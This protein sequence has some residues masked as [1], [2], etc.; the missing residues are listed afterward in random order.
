MQ[1]AVLPPQTI[2]PLSTSFPPQSE[3]SASPSISNNPPAQPPPHQPP[4]YPNMNYAPQNQPWMYGNYY[5]PPPPRYNQNYQQQQGYYPPNGYYSQLP[6][7]GPGPGPG[8][9]Q[10]G[11][12]Y[13]PFPPPGEQS[14][15][16]SHSPPQAQPSHSDY[17]Q[18]PFF[19]PHHPYAYGMGYH[20]PPQQPFG[21]GY[22]G[23]PPPMN[24]NPYPGAKSLNP[25]AQG[26]T[27]NPSTG[28]NP[29][30]RPQ[31][32]VPAQSNTQPQSTIQP[33][34]TIQPVQP[35]PP[36]PSTPVFA[37]IATQ[38]LPDVPTPQSNGFIEPAQYSA[39]I[40]IDGEKLKGLGE[41]RPSISPSGLGLQT[42]EIPTT[43]TP[44]MSS[45]PTSTTPISVRTPKAES[46]NFSLS[47]KG[48]TFGGDA[49]QGLISPPLTAQ[50]SSP[51]AQQIRS[52]SGS[53]T[54]NSRQRSLSSKKKLQPTLGALRLATARPG[55]DDVGNSY[56]IAL[57]S[58][59]PNSVEVVE[60]QVPM[61]SAD[62]TEW[63]KRGKRGAIYGFGTDMS[64]N[65]RGCGAKLMFGEV[66]DEMTEEVEEKVEAVGVAFSREK[67]ESSTDTPVVVDPEEIA[68]EHRQES[69]GISRT[70]PALASELRSQSQSTQPQQ[71]APS[72]PSPSEPISQPRPSVKPVSWAA[73][74]RSSQPTPNP[75]IPSSSIL[76]S[77]AK[78]STP[79]PEVEIE[80]GPSSPKAAPIAPAIATPP[81]VPKPFNYAAAAATGAPTPQ[82][83][84]SRLLVEGIV[85]RKE[86]GGKSA[87]LMR[88]LINTGNMCFA[89]TILQVLVYC[90]PFTDLF[91]ELG[92]RLK[93]DLA[94]RTPLVEAMIIF[95]REFKTAPGQTNNGKGKDR[96]AFV[97]ENVYD[98]M[99]E[100][101]RFDS[102][103][104]GHQEDA[105]EYLGFFLNTLHEELLLLHSRT[106]PATSKSNPPLTPDSSNERSIDRPTSP[107]AGWL[108]V[109]K[110]QK[111]NVVRV[112]SSRESAI[113]KM[114]GGTLRSLLR[115]PH[116]KDSVTLEPYQPL[117]LNLSNTIEN[118]LR[119]ISEPETVKDVYSEK[120]GGKVDAVKTVF[121]EG[122]PKVLILHLKRFVYDSKEGKVVK[123]AKPVA[124]GSELVIPNGTYPIQQV[125]LFELTESAEIISPAKRNAPVKYRLFGVVY[126]H[127]VSASGGHYTLSVSRQKPNASPAA[128]EWVH[129]DD[130]TT[131]EIPVEQVVVSE[132]EV[133]EDRLGTV[134]GGGRDKCAYLL[135]YSRV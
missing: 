31:S 114:F 104:R 38:H 101:K 59:V 43:S 106:Q 110:K 102:M 2:P 77:P 119:M 19:P 5:T 82:E 112:S 107:D 70:T 81:L 27:Y 23:Y 49:L 78:S 21:Y 6:L 60:V 32:T 111:T 128:W 13:P 122:F 18:Q 3:S 7:G 51:I 30:S 48:W 55:L 120:E 28:S 84:L 44:A 89:N 8:T 73:L 75:S 92:K 87:A 72:S 25:A 50:S 34:T 47:P 74:L 11:F 67:V 125:E 105:E 109:G 45:S 83:E 14:Q 58:R 117:Q 127:G 88:G 10:N 80:A 12:G 29:P 118:S 91:E 76:P 108:E 53:E 26:F 9:M 96:E 123:K 52:G 42:N 17:P 4:Y 85:G 62:R 130:E 99:K 22:E 94:R 37:S 69:S 124:Y 65:K 68:R 40:I 24:G 71:S 57:K 61:E 79:L 131:S 133:G 46:T 66:D 116:S 121:L 113:S 98:A 93:A 100:N 135:F 126:H 63:K 16:P 20:P 95:L 129:F 115:T 90:S 35:I 54:S 132:K 56:S 86:I 36:K 33:P 64:N 1:A 41:R 97:P 134:G 15:S 103:R 39:P